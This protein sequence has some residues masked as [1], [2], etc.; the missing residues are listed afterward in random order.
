MTYQY[1]TEE[2]AEFFL[3]MRK[4]SN[5]IAELNVEISRKVGKKRTEKL[6]RKMK[7]SQFLLIGARDELEN[8]A[9]S[10]LGYDNLG[11]EIDNVNNNAFKKIFGENIAEDTRWDED[12]VI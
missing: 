6:R 12:E 5:S 2:L 9:S 3:K 7:E 4:I 1:T 11:I 8:V 10:E